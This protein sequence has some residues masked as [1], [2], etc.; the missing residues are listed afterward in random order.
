MEFLAFEYHRG[1]DQGAGIARV[2]LQNGIRWREFSENVGGELI[3]WNR[4]KIKSEAARHRQAVMLFASD[5]EAKR[6]WQ[7]Q[8]P[9][10]CSVV[11]PCN[12]RRRLSRN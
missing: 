10:G 5:C 12:N 4:W 11:L 9:T 8:A 6:Y 1:R 7:V 2:A 3:P